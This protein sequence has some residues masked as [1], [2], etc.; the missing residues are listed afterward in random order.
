MYIILPYRDSIWKLCYLR[1]NSHLSINGYPVRFHHG[2]RACAPLPET[3]GQHRF[4]NGLCIRGQTPINQWTMVCI[5]VDFFLYIS[6]FLF[7]LIYYNHWLGVGHLHHVTINWVRLENIPCL[8]AILCIIDCIAV[9]RL[10][11]MFATTTVRKLL[12]DGYTDP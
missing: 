1:D 4:P 11:G 5:D 12:F 2:V 6:S 8:L 7:L 10:G 9:L 3:K